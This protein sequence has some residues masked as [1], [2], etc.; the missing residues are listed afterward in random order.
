MMGPLQ[1]TSVRVQQQQQQ[2]PHAQ[3]QG[4]GHD[5]DP[6]GDKCHA[7]NPRT[8]QNQPDT[9]TWHSLALRCQRSAYC[10]SG[11]AAAA[12]CCRSHQPRHSRRA[13]SVS[14]HQSNQTR[15]GSPTSPGMTPVNPLCR[16]GSTSTASSSISLKTRR[17]LSLHDLLS[18]ETTSTPSTQRCTTIHHRRQCGIADCQKYALTGGFCIR[19]GG[20]KR[21]NFE[22]CQ[23]VAQSG[24][25]CKAH[26][27]GS[28][29][30][31]SG[32]GSVA[33]R[34][35][36]CMTHGGRQQCKVDG[37]G[38]CAH[39]GGFCISHGGG[40]RCSS[41]A[42]NKSAQAGGFCYSHGEASVAPRRSASRPRARADSASDTAS[43]GGA[44]AGGGTACRDLV[45]DKLKE[46][47]DFVE[48]EGERK[49]TKKEDVEQVE[50]SL[51]VDEISDLFSCVEQEETS[52]V[53]FTDDVV[54]CGRGDT[55][56]LEFQMEADVQK[57]LERCSSFDDVAAC[58][59]EEDADAENVAM[60]SEIF[61]AT[62][63]D[64]DAAE[65]VADLP[66]TY[67]LVDLPQVQPP[68]WS[69]LLAIPEFGNVELYG[70]GV[71]R[72]EYQRGH[73]DQYTASNQESDVERSSF[74]IRS[75]G[76]LDRENELFLSFPKSAAA[77]C[78]VIF[79]PGDVQD[80]KTVMTT[81]PFADYSDYAY[82]A[83][84]ELL[85]E[86][87]GDTCNVWVVQPSRF[88]HGAYSSFNNFVTTD[89]YGAATKY[90]P[91]AYA[92]KHLASLMQNTQAT[93]RRQ[94][95]NVST[96]LPMHLLGFSK[97]G[98]VLNQLV[99]ELVRYS[100]N[101]KRS[102]S[103]Q[104]RQGSVFASTR[105]FFAAVGFL[106]LLDER[107]SFCF[108][109]CQLTLS[110]YSGQINSIHWLDAGNGSLEGAMPTEET[111]LAVLSRY[112]QLRLF[113]H[114]TPYQYEAR[115]RPW[116]KAEVNSFVNKMNLLGADIQ[117]IMYVHMNWLRC[118]FP[119]NPS[120]FQLLRR[121]RGLSS[122]SFS[123]F[124]RF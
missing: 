56:P 39:G 120:L 124:A 1:P 16:G 103:G 10:R 84:A 78:N 117:L 77:C 86:K 104:V 54:A 26:G 106:F 40:K 114:V 96:A 69:D 64:E 82:E 97:G 47:M 81:G 118:Y 115:Q 113:V 41:K 13:A 24:G 116:I 7:G 63:E 112:E 85:S 4:H 79:F 94:G 33:R 122:I 28:K 60:L 46:R 73:T 42:C 34:K 62:L 49:K 5:L 38:K 76:W 12:M 101:K 109:F 29:C 80:F 18:T 25:R 70:V 93:M 59:E 50:D 65:P 75:R 71:G 100:F 111:A 32:C 22:G 44:R 105:Q 74:R 21:C 27:G 8:T 108:L 14:R 107:E 55:K 83:V 36:F 9:A 20:G 87:F 51:N 31:V 15:R 17:P 119:S 88:K 110:I 67:S 68:T 45:L 92:T 3:P 95:V 43:C 123:Y 89:E 121:R 98:I 30:K 61:S 48:Q 91:T 37:C 90:D 58:Q 99:T 53:D 52:G 102:N 23:T 35:G 57:S 72:P 66:P 11:L 19:H 2:P 6:L